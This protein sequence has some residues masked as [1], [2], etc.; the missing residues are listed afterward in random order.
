MRWIF[1]V[2]Y[3]GCAILVPDV[4][5]H[6]GL[7]ADVNSWR[8]VDFTT[9]L[10]IHGILSGDPAELSPIFIYVDDTFSSLI[11]ELTLPDATA[12]LDTTSGS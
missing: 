10:Y 3:I 7:V 2:A 9:H 6:H 11:C 5:Q 8:L 1:F 4:L 12:G